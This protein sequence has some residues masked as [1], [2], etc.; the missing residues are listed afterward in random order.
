MGTLSKASQYMRASG[1]ERTIAG[2][3]SVVAGTLGA[4][5]FQNQPDSQM[6]IEHLLSAF[7]ERFMSHLL[8]QQAGMY[9]DLFSDDE[10][11]ELISAHGTPAMQKYNLLLPEMQLRGLRFSETLTGAVQALYAELLD[12]SKIRTQ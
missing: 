7:G 5:S 3:V 1:A 6:A 4:S 10:L 12:A 11:D 8:T 9:A 2:T